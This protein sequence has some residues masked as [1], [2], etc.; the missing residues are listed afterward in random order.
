MFVGHVQWRILHRRFRKANLWFSRFPGV[1]R[2]AVALVQQHIEIEL[3]NWSTVTA[4]MDC[5]DL[6]SHSG[7][8]DEEAVLNGIAYDEASGR[9]FV[10]GKLWPKLFEIRVK[11]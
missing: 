7:A 3:S 9:L 11:K 2:P 1:R 8:H 5:A 4:S 6:V 10:T